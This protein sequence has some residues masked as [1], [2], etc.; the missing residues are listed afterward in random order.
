[1]IYG[2]G[3]GVPQNVSLQLE[4]GN[5][6]LKIFL[7]HRLKTNQRKMKFV[8]KSSNHGVALIEVELNGKLFLIL[9]KI[10]QN[11]YTCSLVI[12]HFLLFFIS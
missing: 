4:F 2:L 12:L 6:G 1:M 11:L 5:F 9:L 8:Q 7:F 3:H 10:N